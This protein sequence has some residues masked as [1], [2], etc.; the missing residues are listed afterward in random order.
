[1]PS[2]HLPSPQTMAAIDE[3]VDRILKDLG[4]PQPPLRL[5]DVRE[6][7]RLDLKHYSTQNVTWLDEKVH[8]LRIAGKQ[9]AARPTLLL[10]VVKKLSLRALVLPDRG[11]IL[12]DAEL[13]APKQRWCESHE[14]I[15]KVLPWHAG[16]SFGD[17]DRTLSPTCH[18]LVESEANYGAGRLLFLGSTFGERVRCSGVSMATVQEYSKLFGNSLTTTL[19]R[20]VENLDVPTLGMVSI[21]PRERPANAQSPVRYFIRSKQFA[22][23]FANVQADAL[24]GALRSFCHGRRG[25]I[26]EGEVVV[27]DLAGS[28]HVFHCECFCNG[29]DTLTLGMYRGIRRTLVGV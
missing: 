10:D 16:A 7:L 3:Q 15:H 5:E 20:V 26:G 27:L 4:H 1:M 2:S 11:R 21:H 17:K 29:Y 6:L 19:W 22:S 23:Q 9:I 25:P 18:L 14:I 28:E 12:I 24:F 13:P 8:H